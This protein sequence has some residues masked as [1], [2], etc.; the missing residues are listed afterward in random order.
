MRPLI[1]LCCKEIPEKAS[2]SKKMKILE[3]ALNKIEQSQCRFE[4]KYSM[5]E[6]AFMPIALKCSKSKADFDQFMTPH[7]VA[8][9][10]KTFFDTRQDGLK[11]WQAI[12]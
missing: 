9:F 6:F 3:S 5:F 10:I 4:A 1:T 7:L 8:R 2:A 12:R 11:L